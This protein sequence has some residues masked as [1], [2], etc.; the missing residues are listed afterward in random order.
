MKLQEGESKEE[1]E[2][3]S[4]KSLTSIIKKLDCSY[5]LS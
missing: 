1:R 2:R 3:E 4:N 5:K